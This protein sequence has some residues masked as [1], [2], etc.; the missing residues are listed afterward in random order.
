M[1]DSELRWPGLDRGVMHM[2]IGA[3]SAGRRRGQT[4]M[5]VAPAALSCRP[6]R[7][8]RGLQHSPARR[9]NTIAPDSTV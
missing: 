2:A 5:T 9:L 1:W 6:W 8:R 3:V 4:L 7:A